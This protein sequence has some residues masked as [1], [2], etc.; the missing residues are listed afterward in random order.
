MGVQQF[1]T[2]PTTRVVISA[3]LEVMKVLLVKVVIML[4]ISF[5]V[6]IQSV[7]MADGIPGMKHT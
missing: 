7:A 3:L 5:I 6:L 1:T 2:N 4:T